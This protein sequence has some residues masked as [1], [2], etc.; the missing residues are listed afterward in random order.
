MLCIPSTFG[1][2]R[3]YGT[4]KFVGSSF[5]LSRLSFEVVHTLVHTLVSNKAEN[6]IKLVRLVRSL[7][8]PYYTWIFLLYP[9]NY[10]Q[11][12]IP[13]YPI[14]SHYIP[15]TYYSWRDIP[16]YL[17]M[18]VGFQTLPADFL[19]IARPTSPSQRRRQWKPQGRSQLPGGNL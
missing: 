16:L 5:S 1:C 18:K 7:F 11:L 12:Y 8:Y 9:I 17:P 13:L 4:P 19:L 3:T 14:M 15:T 6:Q 2:V 10:I